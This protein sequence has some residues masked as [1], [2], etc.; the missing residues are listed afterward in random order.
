MPDGAA[1]LPLNGQAIIV[2]PFELL[3]EP[4]AAP[5]RA[6]GLYL[7]GPAHSGGGPQVLWVS[8]SEHY[9]FRAYSDEPA[10]LEDLRV[11]TPFQA[12]VLQRLEPEARK[13]YNYG[14][15]T[16]PHAPR[17]VDASPGGYVPRPAPPTLGLSPIAG[18][19]FEQLY[20]DNYHL[21]LDMA[22]AQSRTTAEADW[23]SFK[24]L[25]SLIAST[26]LMF[27]P[28]RLSIPMVVWQSLG[29]L[30]QGVESALKGDWGEAVAGFASS[31]AQIG[32]GYR[33]PRIAPA[34]LHQPEV[35]SRVRL[36]WPL[37]PG[38]TS[39]PARA[40]SMC[41]WP[42]MYFGCRHGVNAGG[43]IS[44]SS[45]KGRWSGS[46][47]TGRGPSTSRSRCWEAARCC[48]ARRGWPTT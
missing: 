38:C 26:A 21:L 30:Q 7:I 1:R 41:C 8:Y 25:F 31:L 32:T 42:G 36:T 37:R 45:V 28:A 3:A 2:R 19:L 29:S 27:L 15:F 17:Y 16:E 23:E 48:R 43:F 13:T 44:A 10:L 18:N 40:A 24:Y 47:R 11:S 34:A 22:A 46:M 9:T 33:T 35:R 39:T 6:R 20:T 5:D 12:L 14:G 4:D